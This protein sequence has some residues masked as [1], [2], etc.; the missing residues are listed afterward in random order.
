MS[1]GTYNIRCPFCLFDREVPKNID[2]NA[3][4]DCEGCNRR[5][6]FMNALPGEKVVQAEQMESDSD[7]L[8]LEEPEL[9]LET[10][11]ARTM[12]VIFMGA[13]ATILGLWSLAGYTTDM[14]GPSFIVFYLTVGFAILMITNV[15]RW[16]YLDSFYVSTYGA[17][18]FI[19]LAIAR[20][21]EASA[22]G[23]SNFGFMWSICGVGFFTFFFR[24]EIT[25]D[26]ERNSTFFGTCSGCGSSHCSDGGCG[27]GCGGGCGGCG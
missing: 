16:N 19:G 7:E 17:A 20:Y 18:L 8:V 27:S 4:L 26:G 14:D 13:I 25:E 6:Q 1:A 11:D 21:F 15:I 23:M 5:F 3:Q 12:K 24:S 22:Q 9:D 10:R 2:V